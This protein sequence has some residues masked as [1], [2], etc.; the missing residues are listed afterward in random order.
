MEKLFG[1]ALLS[2]AGLVITA[3][4]AAAWGCG[5]C[6]CFMGK[7]CSHQENAFSPFCIDGISLRSCCC[8]GC[9]RRGYIPMQMLQNNPPCPPPAPPCCEGGFCGLGDDCG[10][11]TFGDTPDALPAAP[12][13]KPGTTTTPGFNAPMPT[14]TQPAQNPGST[15]GMEMYPAPYTPTGYQPSVFQPSVFQPMM[16][17]GYGPGYPMMPGYGPMPR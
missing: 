5:N 8:L 4:D 16:N 9:C 14:P 2:L 13:T 3:G 17:P 15:T 10:D 1:T 12:A 6:G 7:I 11:G